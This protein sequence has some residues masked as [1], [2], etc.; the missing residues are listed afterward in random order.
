MTIES[1][2]RALT[3]NWYFRSKI[4]ILVEDAM[5]YYIAARTE[6]DSHWKGEQ[7]CKWLVIDL[8]REREREKR[9]PDTAVDF[10]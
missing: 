10:V 8:N 3:S 1:Q 4:R 6:M 9:L 5:D 7:C 2:R